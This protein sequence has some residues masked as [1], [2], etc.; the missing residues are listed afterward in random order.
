M[1]KFEKLP[2]D[3]LARIPEAIKVLSEDNHVIFAYLFGGLVKGKVNPLSDIDIAGYLKDMDNLAEHKLLLFDKLT[4]ALGTNELDLVI[5]NTAPI[6]LAGRVLQKKEV[7]IDK[8]PSQRHL[9]ES[10][11]LRKFFDFKIK[12]EMFFSRRYGIG[13]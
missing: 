6:S 5:L 4:D 10:L 2:A 13:R 12:E 9:Y 8:A 7:L 11:T 3:I 1:I